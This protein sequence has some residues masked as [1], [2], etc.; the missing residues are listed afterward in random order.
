MEQVTDP[1]ELTVCDL[2]CDTV[3]EVEGGAHLRGGNPDGHVDL[4]RLRQGKVGLQVFACFV[5]SALPPDTAFRRATA[6]L[7]VVDRMCANLYPDFKKIDN[8]SDAEAAI[9]EGRIAVLPAIENGHAI[10]S[11]LGKLK[12]L[13]RR[14][15]RY[16]TLTHS[17]HL[18]WAAS[19]G[20]EWAGSSG[21]TAFGKTVVRE[22]ENLGMIVDISHV[23]ERTFWDVVRIAKKPFI[24]SHSCASALCPMPRNLT[25]EQIK[26]IA[27]SG[28][29]VGIN[30]YP[31]F[32]DPS[33]FKEQGDSLTEVFRE[34]DRIEVELAD[35]PAR[36]ILESH[37]AAQ[38]MRER[39]GPPRAD[40]GSVAAHVLHAVRLVGDDHVG[41]GG[42]LDGLPE[43]P[44]DIPDC[45]AYPRILERLAQEGLSRE[46]LAKIAGGN[47][48]RVL[49][50][51]D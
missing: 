14:G 34:F 12:Q 3:L 8:A 31:G 7:D 5:S 45:G 32:L 17:R 2:H 16:M 51:N 41:F 20:E 46:S 19:S 35:D 4:A 44:R 47:F 13:R 24:A 48:L 9:R 1:A 26:A 18:P 50:A 49:K 6:L 30:F 42:D 11:T 22:M 10:E 21:L 39:L 28:G 36:K 25:D 23:H 38:L 40:I 37:R 33:Y 15:V 27:A 43:L 29:M